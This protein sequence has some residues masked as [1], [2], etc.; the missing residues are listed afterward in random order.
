MH[1]AGTRP[2]LLNGCARA[3]TAE[4]ARFRIDG[5][6][7]EPRV[8]RVVALDPGAE[9]ILAATASAPW[10]GAHF[11]R[12]VAPAAGDAP[13]AGSPVDLEEL[14]GP[15]VGLDEILDGADLAV[16]VATGDEGAGLAEAIGAAAGARGVMTAGLIFGDPLSATASVLRPQAR[17]LL[18]SSDDRDLADLLSALRA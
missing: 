16:L 8:A 4:E 7:G 14:G 2:T 11:Y 17:V 1:T 10:A 9:A 13:A 3:A 12:R 6:L 18:V 15:R 5:P